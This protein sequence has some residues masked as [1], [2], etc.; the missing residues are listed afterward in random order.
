VIGFWIN[1]V[2][3]LVIAAALFGGL[4]AVAAWLYRLSV[5]QPLRVPVARTTTEMAIWLG[6]FGALLAG[7]V[8]Y[9]GSAIAVDYPFWKAYTLP[10]RQIVDYVIAWLLFM[11]SL[12]WFGA[13]LMPRKAPK[14]AEA[15]EV[16]APSLEPEAD[17]VESPQRGS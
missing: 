15:E 3:G 4:L 13:T 8:I 2:A 10:Q 16:E 9:L 11:P 5:G 12:F 14:A 17:T 6:V 1:L 7:A